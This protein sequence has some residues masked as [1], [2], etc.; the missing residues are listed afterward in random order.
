[1]VKGLSLARAITVFSQQEIK[2]LFHT[3]QT[4]LNEKGL[5]IRRMP[6]MRKFGRILIIIPRHVGS[7]VERNLIRRRIKSIFYQEQLYNHHYDGIVFVHKNATILS[8]ATL[9]ELLKK[10]FS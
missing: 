10:G 4:V 3:A 8:F 7:A 2:S 1:V 9:K 6:M 5:E